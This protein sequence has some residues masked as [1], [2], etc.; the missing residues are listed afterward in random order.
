MLDLWRSARAAASGPHSTPLTLPQRRRGKVERR[1]P[2]TGEATFHRVMACAPAAWTAVA[3]ATALA[4]GRSPS[5]WI[6]LRFNRS[7]RPG[8]PLPLHGLVPPCPDGRL[9]RKSRSPS[10]RRE[11]QNAEPGPSALSRPRH[12]VSVV[13]VVVSLVFTAGGFAL[14]NLRK[15]RAQVRARYQEMTTALSTG[16]STAV[17][18]LI[19]PSLR[20]GLSGRYLSTLESFAKPLGPQSSIL[21]LG[22]EAMVWPSRSWHR[23]IFPRGHTVEMLKIDGTWFFTGEVHID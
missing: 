17:L 14:S 2:P 21:I 1:F 15:E 10:Q 5:A 22:H 20:S 16:D 19:A 3:L 7:S 12:S 4:V 23:G 9:A 18:S 13:I 11:I 6:R 8:S